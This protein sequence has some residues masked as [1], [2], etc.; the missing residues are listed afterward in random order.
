MGDRGFRVAKLVPGAGL[1]PARPCEREI[2]SLLCLPIPPP[3]HL[4][5]E[6]PLV[7]P[8]LREVGMYHNTWTLQEYLAR[9][10]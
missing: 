1:E 6:F 7:S 2:L 5:V 8:C 4:G 10:I 9:T 3:G